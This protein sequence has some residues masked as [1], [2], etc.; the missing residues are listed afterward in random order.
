MCIVIALFS[1]MGA[2]SIKQGHF[3]FK[4][5]WGIF[6][7]HWDW[8]LTLMWILVVTELICRSEEKNVHQQD[9]AC[10]GS[11]IK[12]MYDHLQNAQASH[13]GTGSEPTLPPPPYLSSICHLPSANFIWAETSFKPP[14]ILQLKLDQSDFL[15]VWGVS[16]KELRRK[17]LVFINNVWN[18]A[19]TI[20]LYIFCVLLINRVG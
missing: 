15:W 14:P 3:E 1:F 10:H 5:T 9:K 4:T 16:I 8:C 18:V 13:P 6:Q 12:N 2:A 20:S 7:W 11:S 17:L 19:Y